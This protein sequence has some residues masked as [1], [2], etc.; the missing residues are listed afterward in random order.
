MHLDLSSVDAQGLIGPREGKRAL[1]YELC[2]PGD[3]EKLAAVRAIDPSLELQKGSP[4]RIGCG[5][6]E[7]LA[8]GSTH[9]PHWLSVLETLAELPYVE[10]IEPHWAE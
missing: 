1:S 9:Q 6:G 7:V 3:E 8:I 2:V 5:E 10:R 4:G